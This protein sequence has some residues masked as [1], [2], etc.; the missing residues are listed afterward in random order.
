MTM[1]DTKYY[2]I[3]DDNKSLGPYSKSRILEML[4]DNE[5]SKETLIWD[6][7]NN[8]HSFQKTFEIFDIDKEL[9][10]STSNSL[11][12]EKSNCDSSVD[13]IDDVSEEIH[14]IELKHS[15]DTN[16]KVNSFHPWKRFFAVAID[17]M[18][19]IIC[20]GMLSVCDP[21]GV[22]DWSSINRYSVCMLMIST[23]YYTLLIGIYGT[24]IG[25]WF[26]GIKIVDSKTQKPIGIL[27]GLKRYLILYF[28]T[29]WCIGLIWIV[30]NYFFNK[31]NAN[32]F[33][34]TMSNIIIS[35]VPYIPLILSY[36]YYKKHGRTKWDDMLNIDVLYKR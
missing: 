13:G 31:T 2:F 26:L 4:S 22:A 23:L 10:L 27:K 18:I 24:C 34:F 8:F 32:I 17:A 36:F 33:V 15:I 3:F 35:V 5:I 9:Q 29:T 25:K 16:S 6:C 19:F 11:I 7:R 14:K 12:K 20:Y 28:Y 21:Y 1:K 30:F